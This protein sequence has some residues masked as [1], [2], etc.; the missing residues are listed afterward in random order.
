M[1]RRACRTLTALLAVGFACAGS[2]AEPTSKVLLHEAQINQPQL[3]GQALVPGPPAP[4]LVGPAWDA[5][6]T[7]PNV[8]FRWQPGAGQTTPVRYEICVTELNQPCTGPAAAIYRTTGDVINI[9]PTLGQPTLNPKP[10]DPGFGRPPMS[11]GS[12]SPIYFLPAVLPTHFKGKRLQWWVT[13]CVPD[14]RP[15]RYA[16]GTAPGAPA[17]LC[18]ASAS[19]IMSW[20]LSVP[21]LR[22]PFNN[23][24][25]STLTDQFSWDVVD[26][27]GIEYF[28]ICFATR[29]TACPAAPGVQP[30][31]V[32]AQ[33][34]S[35]PAV[36]RTFTPRL[37]SLELGSMMGETLEWTV[38]ACNSA[39]GCTYQPAR[40]SFHVPIVEGSWDS[41]YAVTQN[42]KCKNC[43]QMW[44]ENE[45]YQ[46][47]INLGRF[48]REQNPPGRFN[49]GHNGCHQCH[50]AAAGFADGW[51][52]PSSDA[53]LD[54]PRTD[55]RLCRAL[56][57]D[58]EPFL[59]GNTGAPHALQDPLIR[60]AVNHIAGLGH[61]AWAQ[62]F[63]R[64]SAAGRPCCS[65]PKPGGCVN[66]PPHGQFGFVR[67]DTRLS[68]VVNNSSEPLSVA[69]GNQPAPGFS[70]PTVSPGAYI[71]SATPA[72]VCDSTA[73]LQANGFVISTVAG[74]AGPARE[75][76]RMCQD[77]LDDRLYFVR[78]GGGWQDRLLCAGFPNK[79]LGDVKVFV[80]ATGLPTCATWE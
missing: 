80:Q 6:L 36:P 12:A 29:G 45:T 16:P 76:F 19:R 59:S 35:V 10:G 44:S 58:N 7:G 22:A 28:L 68:L 72:P 24:V 30:S 49:D 9:E 65:S 61:S 27:L 51:R 69:F 78:A 47:H 13:A 56:K 67:W 1:L 20:A 39:L 63:S 52:F 50:T 8:R 14:P 40:S 43:H 21:T 23:T 33:V 3:I 46:R 2:A 34:P 26:P 77:S 55:V 37:R 38:A 11:E 17:E 4:G 41:M 31:V 18:T 74:N 48:T 54:V 79:L 32:V 60:W 66:E 70:S 73:E 25:L 64:W 75:L 53:N 15:R 5:T 42:V 57:V 62:R 71:H